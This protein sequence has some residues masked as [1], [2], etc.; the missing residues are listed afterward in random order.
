MPTLIA[1]PDLFPDD[2][3]TAV[4]QSPDPE[5]R[6]WALY[7]RSRQEKELMR[8]LRAMEISFYGPTIERRSR[9]PGGRLRTAHLP[10]FPNYVFMYGDASQRWEALTTNRV[11]R[12]IAVVDSSELFH[13]LRQ[14]RNLIL[15]GVPIVPE[16]RLVPGMRVR[17]KSGPLT[18]QE[19][20]VLQRRGESRLLVAVRFLQQGASV[21]MDECELEFLA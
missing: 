4:D 12:D 1:E 13:D 16:D 3:F 9:T 5:R 10:L 20:T 2:L 14:L 18:G 21:Q 8:R 19:G 11:S 15:S 7:T 6:W 17:V